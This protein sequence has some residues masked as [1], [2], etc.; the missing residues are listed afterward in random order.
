MNRT[1][2]IGDSLFKWGWAT[3]SQFNS[4]E[5]ARQKLSLLPEFK[6]NDKC[7]DIVTFEVK[8]PIPVRE[9]WVGPLRSQQTGQSFNGGAKQWEFLISK[10]DTNMENFLQL[11]PGSRKNLKWLDLKILKVLI[12]MAI[13]LTCE[14]Y[15]V[16]R[17]L[18]YLS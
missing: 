5:E 8:S 10:Y 9:G 15:R 18:F 12:Q 13:L 14:L 1:D 17:R 16:C 11:V 3:P 2:Y 6:S 4:V 7:C